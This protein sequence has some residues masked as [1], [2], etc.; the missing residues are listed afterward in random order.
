MVTN[1]G[2]FAGLPSEVSL[3]RMSADSKMAPD[4]KRNYKSLPPLS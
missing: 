3:V 4:L 2:S 1:T